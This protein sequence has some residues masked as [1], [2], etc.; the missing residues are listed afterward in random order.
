M[1]EWWEKAHQAIIK[2]G[3]K[4]SDISLM[5]KKSNTKF[6]EGAERFFETSALHHV[7]LL[8]FSAGIG[9]ILEEVIRQRAKFHKNM[10]VISNYIEFSPVDGKIQGFRGKTIHVF[11]KNE[12]AVANNVCGNNQ[13]DI[14]NDIHSRKNVLLLGDGLGDLAMSDGSDFQEIIRIGFLNDKIQERL[15]SYKKSFDIVILNDG[16]FHKVNEI[17]TKICLS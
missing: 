4:V 12:F 7:P 11:N 16:T 3:V 15:E 8:I 2:S 10:S 17:L 1:E 6:R 13:D 9:N 5:V 14:E